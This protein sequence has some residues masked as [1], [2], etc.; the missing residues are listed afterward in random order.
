MNKTS[1]IC[2]VLLTMASVMSGCST[3]RADLPTGTDAYAIIPPT[4]GMTMLREYRIAPGDAVSVTVYREPDLSLPS[5]QVDSAGKIAMPLV[6]TVVAAGHTAEELSATI[7]DRLNTSFVRD[8]EVVVNVTSAAS[9]RIVVEGSVNQPGVFELR[10]DTTLLGAM[11]MARGP[12]Q[13]AALEEVA[14]FRRV[15]GKLYAAKFDLR[16][17]RLGK[18]P[19]P[20]ILANDTI[21]VGFSGLKSAYRDVLQALPA[22]AVFR[23]L[24]D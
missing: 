21:V 8:P 15:E 23:P 19:D 9:Q 17:I 18:A 10:G 14:V 4:S 11:A 5:I 12:S 7:R 13:I 3:P 16:D 20:A 2:S 24:Y 1:L 22:A 6:G